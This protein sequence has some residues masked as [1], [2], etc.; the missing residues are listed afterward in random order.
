MYKRKISKIFKNISIFIFLLLI[1][2]GKNSIKAIELEQQKPKTEVEL[3][4]QQD[5]KTTELKMEEEKEKEN[6]RKENSNFL[7][8]NVL[9]KE[10]DKSTNLTT[11]SNLPSL[12]GSLEPT[13]KSDSTIK[14][15]SSL[16]ENGN[17]V[18]PKEI[19]QFLTVE[20]KN[21]VKF[22]VLIDYSKID[23]NVKFLTESTESDMLN[24]ISQK[25]KIEAEKKKK[26][27][28]EKQEKEKQNELEKQ[29]K[30][31]A[32]E[33]VKKEKEIK[34][35]KMQKKLLLILIIISLIIISVIIFKKFK[36][37]KEFIIKRWKKNPEGVE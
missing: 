17:R 29:Q 27:E 26:E 4:L 3:K 11:G 23:K 33:N 35:K 8:H 37:I 32:E 13:K 10:T 36:I 5:G 21:G 12:P 9:G 30:K 28:L 15:K 1:V 18:I 31:A 34:N 2:L 6:L 22:H 25:E 20:S 19:L 24:I 14:L 16:D 7:E